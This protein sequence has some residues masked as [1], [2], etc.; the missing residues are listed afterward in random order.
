MRALTLVC[1][2]LAALVL[3]PACSGDEAGG[4][5]ATTGED[6]SLARAGL[7]EA[8]T[9]GLEQAGFEAEPGLGF[10]VLV[11]QGLN[12]VDV[13]LDE[14]FREYLA[15]R[16]RRA[17]LV[18]R[19][20]RETRERFGE[21]LADVSFEEARA[22][23]MP[24]LKPGFQL[25]KLDPEPIS[26]PFLAN[27]SVIYAVERENDFTV[28]SAADAERWGRPLAELHRIA[29][30]NLLR[31]TNREE[32]LLCEPSGGEELCG[33]AS[34][35]GYDATRMIVP[36]LRKQIERKYGEPAVYA[37]PIENV[38]VALPRRLAERKN[39]VRLLRTKVERD[40]ATAKM[41][42]SPELFVERGGK[43]VVF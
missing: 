43:L 22:S 15:D 31:Q 24:V 33:W 2:L 14:E 37:V 8:V 10:R 18:A 30:R 12:R 19:V 20:V 23:L 21:G 3:A 27:L 11:E 41:P 16:S 5:P 29:L 36:G 28:V 32:K 38:F 40:F 34:G 9:S 7:K 1:V 25:R 4:G 13:V 35:D 26:T 6:V 42:V 17:E 39:T